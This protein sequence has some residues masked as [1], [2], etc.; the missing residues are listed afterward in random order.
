MSHCTVADTDHFIN[1]SW[2]VVS[3]VG[4]FLPTF[5]LSPLKLQVLLKKKK[6]RLII[7]PMDSTVYLCY[8]TSGPSH[9][10]LIHISVLSSGS[11]L[12]V[13]DCRSSEVPPTLWF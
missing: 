1:T 3:A 2:L 5:L 10:P 11:P 8:L 13:S 6:K 7:V 12:A 9:N 4:V